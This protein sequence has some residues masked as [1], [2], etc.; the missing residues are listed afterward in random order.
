MS[1]RA[2]KVLRKAFKRLSAYRDTINVPEPILDAQ[3]ELLRL[4]VDGMDQQSGEL[5]A[6]HNTYWMALHILGLKYKPRKPHKY[7]N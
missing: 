1:Q 4:A 2:D 5:L 6:L 3:V 7:S